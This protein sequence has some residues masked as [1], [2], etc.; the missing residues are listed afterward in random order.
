V[1]GVALDRAGQ[2]LAGLHNC[3]G[4]IGTFA[5]LPS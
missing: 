2:H 3:L 5:E 1:E 4:L